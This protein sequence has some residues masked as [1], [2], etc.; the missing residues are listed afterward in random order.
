MN[1]QK[2]QI[3]GKSPTLNKY[4]FIFTHEVGDLEFYPTY[5]KLIKSQ[6]KPYEDRRAE[7]EK[8]LRNI[9]YYSY[10]NVPY[11]HRLFN[12]LGLK[13]DSIRKLEDLQKLPI[14][15]KDI[16]RGNWE[17]FK[18][19]HLS[20]MKYREETT[21]GSTGTPFKYRI[22]N[23]D[24]FLSGA[25]L[26]RGW[27]YGGYQLGDKTI[28]LAGTSLDV[29]TKPYLIKR[30]HEFARNLRKLS[31][32]DMDDKGMYQF[33]NIIN[34]FKPKFLRG[35]AS[36]IYFFARWL[37]EKDISIHHPVS[38]FTTSEKLYPQMREKIKKVF[39]CDVFD[40][41]GLNDSGVTAF[42]CPEHRGMHIDTERSVAE[43]I[44]GAGNSIEEGE[45][46]IIG[47][48]L[49]NYA[50]PFI[51][52]DT[53]DIGRIKSEECTCGRGYKMLSDICGRSG[54][55]LFTPE[56]KIINSLFFATIF[57]DALSVREYQIVQESLNN[58]VI[59][60][61]P[62]QNFEARQ[63]NDF[64]RM[65]KA[66]SEGWKIEFDVVDR[67]EKTGAGKYK[68]VISKIAGEY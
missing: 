36:S 31:S 30:F 63:L 44:D 25:I 61:A 11:Y 28:F 21:G 19:L 38:V 47:T 55:L 32:F 60:I 13:P 57:D 12:N 54:D 33:V 23:H 48:S 14:L 29:G 46:R 67:I 39:D 16:I 15:T 52:Y 43:V 7:Q 6:W 68:Y 35:Y 40:G 49:H 41:Y 51:R 18:P 17:D 20:R 26:Y 24:R 66:R 10:Y 62:N 56:G 37:E 45:G 34:S 65:I 53:G 27:G 3:P 9:I 2:L 4:L 8:Q 42:E 5:N 64:A 22:S 58:I 50:M 1:A 59:R